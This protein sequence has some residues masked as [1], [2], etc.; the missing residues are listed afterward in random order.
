MVVRMQPCQSRS[1]VLRMHDRVGRFLVAHFPAHGWRWRWRD[2]EQFIGLGERQMLVAG[3]QRGIEAKVYPD[4]TAHDL[5]SVHFLADSDGGF[6]VKEGNYDSAEGL[7]RRPSVDSAMPV[8]RLANL[9]EI[10]RLENLWLNEI[11][12]D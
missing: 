1:Q 7:E 10:R 2:E 8:Y 5:L 11:C 6:G 4:P 3:V 12:D 9:D